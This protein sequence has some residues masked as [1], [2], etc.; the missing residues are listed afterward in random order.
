[1]V[2][3]KHVTTLSHEFRKTIGKLFLLSSEILLYLRNISTEASTF[4]RNLVPNLKLTCYQLYNIYLIRFE[5]GILK[6]HIS[7]GIYG[8][9]AFFI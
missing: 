8:I 1:M 9:Q 7:H 3:T 2:M 6:G 5:H 4:K